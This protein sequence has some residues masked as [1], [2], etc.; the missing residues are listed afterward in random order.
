MPHKIKQQFNLMIKSPLIAQSLFSVKVFKVIV[1][2]NSTRINCVC[3]TFFSPWLRLANLLL[4]LQHH[5]FLSA[6]QRVF[7]FKRLSKLYP[8]INLICH[9]LKANLKRVL[10]VIHPNWRGKVVHHL[11]EEVEDEEG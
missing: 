9:T 6:S 1:P 10:G 7:F 2:R 3:C 11:V 4:L 5:T 8:L